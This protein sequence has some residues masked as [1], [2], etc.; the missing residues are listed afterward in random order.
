MSVISLTITESKDEVISGIPRSIT[1]ATSSPSIIFYTLDGTQPS[2]SSTVYT[3]PIMMPQ[4]ADNITFSVFATDGVNSSSIFTKT[5]QTDIL[6]NT[7]MPRAQV[8]NLSPN[9]NVSLFPFGTNSPTPDVEYDNPANTGI[10]VLNP[11][12]PSIPNAY[13]A[14]GQPTTFTN[15]QLINYQ[16]VYSESDWQGKTGPGIGTLPQSKIL[17][18]DGPQDYRQEISSRSD[19]IFNPKA[20]VVYQ[21]ASSEGPGDPLMINR[22]YFTLENPEI[23]INGNKLMTSASEANA[24][25]GSYLRSYYNARTNDITNYFYDNTVGRWIISKYQYQPNQSINDLS[26]IVYPRDSKYVFKWI[27]FQRRALF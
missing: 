25:G 16:L 27:P 3:E 17:D 24:G 18:N 6:N 5:Y 9:S 15:Q 4:N 13:D 8:N 10:T 19:K 22:Q 14:N 1:V 12:L 23:V 2:T 20:M 21:D 11:T 26:Q 7:R